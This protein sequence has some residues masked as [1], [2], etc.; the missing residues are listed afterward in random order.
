MRSR[1]DG[2]DVETVME[3]KERVP[4]AGQGGEGSGG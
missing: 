4:S 2:E 3:S 1:R